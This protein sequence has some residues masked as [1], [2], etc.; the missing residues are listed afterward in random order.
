VKQMFPELQWLG[1]QLWI[2]LH[3]ELY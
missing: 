3:T 1:D 2:N